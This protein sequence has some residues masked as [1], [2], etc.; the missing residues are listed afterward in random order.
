MMNSSLRVLPRH[1]FPLRE[2]S[3]RS[4]HRAMKRIALAS[5]LA[6]AACQG[7]SSGAD[8]MAAKISDVETTRTVGTTTTF[9]RASL[10]YDGAKL[11]EVTNARN[12]APNGIA[13]VTYGKSGIERIEYIDKEGD[14]ATDTLTY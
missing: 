10:R 12:G 11:A 6:V 14:K 2:G 8:R 3:P 5:V 13:K 9:D 4:I 1:S 7:G